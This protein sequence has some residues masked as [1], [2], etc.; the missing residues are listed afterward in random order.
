M[1]PHPTHLAPILALLTLLAAACTAPAAPPLPATLPTR[2][3]AAGIGVCHWVAPT[4]LPDALDWGTE[5]TR[6]V[7][8]SNIEAVRD[9]YNLHLLNRYI[10][11]RRAS[12]V[13][14]WLGFQTYGADAAGQPKAPQWVIDD[15][16]IWHDAGCGN[17]KAI[18]APW[19]PIYLQRLDLL[20][21]AINLHITSQ[22]QAY[23]DTIAG[24]VMMTGG[25]YGEAHLY[26]WSETCNIETALREHYGLTHL[27]P[28]Q[29]DHLYAQAILRLLD[30]YMTAFPDWPIMVQLGRPFA[31]EMLLHYA[32]TTYPGRLYAKWAG[33]S[34]ENVGD[35]RDDA[36]RNGN[37]HYTDLF[38]AYHDR[39]PCGFEPAHPTQD[40]T[41]PDQYRSAL[42]VARNA[43]VTF[44]CFQAGNTLWNA[45]ALPEWA[46][47][48]AELEANAPA[49]IT[50][51]PTPTASPTATRSPTL[52]PTATP[53]HPPQL[54]IIWQCDCRPVTA[55]PAP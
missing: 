43:K 14:S 7:H 10:A 15:G 42:Q 5:S 25:V 13:A 26:E 29:F 54:D 40:W 16:A 11:N 21:Q 18:F 3:A 52:T 32:S 38:L 33:W 8:W 41:G 17:H 1:T 48:D 12:H 22:D 50:P 37:Q 20:L 45:Y 39:I 34:P 9:T 23:R 27:T 30:I 24:I 28:Q 53:T 49:A 36:R 55:T 6:A 51:T 46:A 19:D 31:D 2:P 35:G 47:L 4:G 44:A